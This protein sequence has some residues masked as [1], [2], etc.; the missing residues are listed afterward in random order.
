MS[1]RFATL[2]NLLLS[3][4]DSFVEVL[5]RS[6]HENTRFVGR[7]ISFLKTGTEICHLRNRHGFDWHKR[8][9]I[10]LLHI[11]ETSSMEVTAA[12]MEL[13]EFSPTPLVDIVP[14]EVWDYEHP[15]LITHTHLKS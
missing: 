5:Q 6:L 14:S 3:L 15:T 8:R 1:S 2:D 9:A 11:Q 10:N 7:A 4:Q 13:R 12:L